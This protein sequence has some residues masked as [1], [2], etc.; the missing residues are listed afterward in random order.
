[1]S[2]ARRAAAAIAVSAAG[3]ALLAWQVARAGPDL[4]V[5]GLAQVGWGFAAILAL[6]FLRFALRSLAW[7]TLM[8]GTPP[9]GPAIGATLAGDAIG[10]LTPLSLLVSEPA[11]S[12]YYRDHL[13]ASQSFPALTAENFFYSVSVAIF[14]TLGTAAMLLSVAVP[15]ELR[16]AGLIALALM[17]LVLAAALWIGWRQPI[18][19]SRIAARVPVR[20]VAALA[21]RIR[22]FETTTYELLR[23]S[24]RS[25]S[26]VAI[27]LGCEAGFHLLSFAEAYLTIWLMTGRSAPLAAFVLDTFNR[28]V[29]VVF[30][31][32]PLRIGVDEASTALVAPAVGLSPAVGVTIAL[33]RKGRMLVWACAGVALAIRKGMT[34]K[35]VAATDPP[36]TRT[37]GHR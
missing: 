36:A 31:A 33:V 20:A 6:S 35:D 10:N 17:A 15:V 37:A 27:L 18:L 2:R 34:V 9:V 12:I 24:R 21:A 4:I 1:M 3:A 32:M 7:T 16:W 28:I 5:A 11:K 25:R 29:N 14:I 23:E 30:R 26:T 22:R 13:P 8:P 19:L